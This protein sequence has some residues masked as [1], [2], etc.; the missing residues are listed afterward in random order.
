MVTSAREISPPLIALK[1]IAPTLCITIFWA[2]ILPPLLVKTPSLAESLSSSLSLISTLFK[3]MSP[4]PCTNASPEPNCGATSTLCIS[5]LYEPLLIDWSPVASYDSN[6]FS[7]VDRK[8]ALGAL[9]TISPCN[10]KSLV[11]LHDFVN[12]KAPLCG[13]LHVSHSTVILPTILGCAVH[14]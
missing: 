6:T 9:I 10:E 14:K 8:R 11:I 13:K 7:S 2:I 4:D 12:E 3:I 5:N 1:D